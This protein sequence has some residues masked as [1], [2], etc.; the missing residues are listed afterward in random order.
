MG[1]SIALSVK[2]AWETYPHYDKILLCT[3]SNV[4]DQWPEDMPNTQKSFASD[5]KKQHFQV[6]AR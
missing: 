6:L 2:V 1:P 5:N 3:S 4:I